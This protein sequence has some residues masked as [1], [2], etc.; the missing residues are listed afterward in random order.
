VINLKI[1]ALE[2]LQCRF[3]CCTESFS[4]FGDGYPL[5]FSHFFF[6]SYRSQDSHRRK[7]AEKEILRK[8]SQTL[9][10]TDADMLKAGTSFLDAIEKS[11]GLGYVL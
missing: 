10:T 8:Q 6:P 11:L 2:S 1:S 3:K 4:Q 7:D 9:P 5:S